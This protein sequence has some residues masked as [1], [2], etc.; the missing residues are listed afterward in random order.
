M[1]NG[2]PALPEALSVTK[3]EPIQASQGRTLLWIFSI[4]QLSKVQKNK[5]QKDV[6]QRTSRISNINSDL[7]FQYPAAESTKA[8]TTES[9]ENEA[10]KGTTHSSDDRLRE[11]KSG[12][13][14]PLQ[15]LMRKHIVDSLSIPRATKRR[16]HSQ[17][18]R[19]RESKV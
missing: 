15:C 4:K 14:G 19:H 1:L 5:Y 10:G 8:T 3:N 9:E 7:P 16:Q 13:S 11:D 17:V 12:P 6:S 2:A 18:K